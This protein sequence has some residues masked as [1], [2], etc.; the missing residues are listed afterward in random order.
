MAE[1][2]EFVYYRQQDY[3]RV[4]RRLPS[5]IVDLGVLVLMIAII[6]SAV[7]AVYVP[8]SVI[9]MPRSPERNRLLAQYWRPV[10]KQTLLV[11]AAVAAGYHI[12]LRRTRGGTLGYRLLG[13][14]LI[15]A[16]GRPPSWKALVKRFLI[17]VPLFFF[18]AATYWGCFQNPRRQALHDTF[19]STWLVRKSAQP[20]GPARP[21]HQAKLLGPWLL[22]FMDVEPDQDAD[23]AGALENSES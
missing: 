6:T 1:V 5:M 8:G 13:I 15:D 18:F 14:R 11:C 12:A 3:A 21:V 2:S 4:I 7:Q 20:A 17:A 10:Q 19:C 23:R 22:T 9:K 16:T